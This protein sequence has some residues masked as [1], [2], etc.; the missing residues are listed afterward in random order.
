MRRIIGD[1]IDAALRPI[2]V[3]RLLGAIANSAL[4]S[5]VG[6]WAIRRLH[7]GE[8]RL[9]VAYVLAAV[10]G[11]A[12]GYVGGH[13]SDRHGRR[14]IVLVSS[15][16]SA[17]VGV[18]YLVSGRHVYLGLG[19]FVLAACIQD[20]GRAANQAMVMDVVAPEGRE[21]AFA[22]VRVASNLGV[23]IGPVVGSAF[24]VAGWTTFFVGQTLMA[25]GS[26]IV[27]RR[28]I[29]HRGA[30]S[31]DEPPRSGSMR[32]IAGDRVFLAFCVAMALSQIVYF[33]YETVLP[34]S[35]TEDHG[36]SPSAW[37][38]LVIL[39]P[40][41]VTLLQMRLTRWSGELRLD[42]KLAAAMLLMGLPFLALAVTDAL[43]SIVVLLLL[44]VLGEMLWVPA[45][46]AVV[47]RMSPPDLRGAYMGAFTGTGSMGL[48]LAPFVGLQVRALAGDLAM[49]S[50]LAGVAIVAAVIM[51]LV[52]RMPAVG[53]APA[54]A[55]AA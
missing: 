48:A 54:A 35:L 6:I 15:G 3:V 29:P 33:A 39:N 26:W 23:T 43:A 18:G 37:G 11:M 53:V 14:P 28:Y 31:S 55:P 50:A 13:L 52:C 51:V 21:R 8:S 20:L 47:S 1:D 5:F 40:A 17:L 45:S 49:W 36:V 38:L 32:V 4:F 27:A 24:L 34:I 7:A 30:Y 22:A 46:Q 2:I 16:L 25:V 9:S 12:A 10:V 42:V 19:V 41:A 44:F